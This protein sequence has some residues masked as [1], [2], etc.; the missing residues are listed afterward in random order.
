MGPRTWLN[1]DLEPG[2][3]FSSLQ[4]AS[5][6]ISAG[7]YGFC[8]NMA[9]GFPLGGKEL[10]WIGLGFSLR[11]LYA[12]FLHNSF[13]WL[14]STSVGTFKC[15]TIYYR[16]SVVRSRNPLAFQKCDSCNLSWLRNNLQKGS[17]FLPPTWP[18]TKQCRLIHKRLETQKAA[19]GLISCFQHLIF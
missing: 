6:C 18:I 13:H 12:L 4:P 11:N 10:F 8:G 1:G 3:A 5:T 15:Q 19:A 17:L 9:P 7:W 14:V 16:Q 2:K